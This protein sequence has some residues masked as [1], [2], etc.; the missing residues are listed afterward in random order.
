MRG[1]KHDHVVADEVLDPGV[2]DYAVTSLYE[3]FPTK[4]N[5]VKMKL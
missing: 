5:C 4:V 3:P 2:S 1:I